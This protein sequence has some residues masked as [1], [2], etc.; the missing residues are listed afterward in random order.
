MTLSPEKLNF[1][2]SNYQKLRGQSAPMD[3]VAQSMGADVSSATDLIKGFEGFRGEAYMPTPNDVPTV[4]YGNTQGVQMGQ[5]ITEEE[6]SKQ[7]QDRVNNLSKQIDE[8]VK[9]PLTRNQ[10]T[11]LISLADNVGIGALGM[12]E[13][14]RRLNAGD[15]EGF[16]QGAFGEGGFIRQKGEILPGLVKR[17]TE[18]ARL[19]MTPDGP[20]TAQPKEMSIE[21]PQPF[22]RPK[23]WKDTADQIFRLPQS[24]GEVVTNLAV[25][26]PMYMAEVIAG[27][28]SLPFD[29]SA[30]TAKKIGQ[31]GQQIMAPLA[32]TTEWGNQAL[33][34]IGQGFEFVL[35]PAH[36]V[37]D[38]IETEGKRPALA[39]LTR[40]AGEFLTLGA[41]HQGVVNV[42][43]GVKIPA[44]LRRAMQREKLKINPDERALLN[45]L[46]P[47]AEKEAAEIISNKEHPITQE[48]RDRQAAEIARANAEAK[49]SYETLKGVMKDVKPQPKD[50]PPQAQSIMETA[51]AIKE[52]RDITTS[53][54]AVAQRRVQALSE[55][56][57][58]LA[59]RGLT[60]V[61]GKGVVKLEDVKPAE[62]KPVGAETVVEQPVVNPRT[63]PQR[64]ASVVPE[65]QQV[66]PEV[67]PEM[68]RS[69]N[70]GSNVIQLKP[71]Q[72]VTWQ[73]GKQT[74]E[75]EILSAG[76]KNRIKVITS[77]GKVKYPKREL[78]KIEDEAVKNI[79]PEAEVIK[80]PVEQPV[81]LDQKFKSDPRSLTV[82]ELKQLE[83]ESL[84]RYQDADYLKADSFEAYERSLNDVRKELRHR[85]WFEIPD[86]P[87]IDPYAPPKRKSFA[88][89]LK[90]KEAADPAFDY[91]DPGIFKDLK[92]AFGDERGALFPEKLTPEQARVKAEAIERLVKKLK[93]TG[94][95]MVDALIEAGLDPD[96]AREVA[97]KLGEKIDEMGK[98]PK[99]LLMDKEGDV[100]VK[101][102]SWKFK[103]Q[104][105]KKPPVFMSDREAMKRTPD[106]PDGPLKG[107]WTPAIR[108]FD[109]LDPVFKELYYKEREARLA[110]D[111]ELKSE[112]EFLH[113]LSK[114]LS[115]KE[116]EELGA[117]W[118]NLQENGGKIL[119]EMGVKVVKEL[120]AN[121]EKAFNVLTSKFE[122]LFNRI[123]NAR[124]SIGQRPMSKV[125][126]YLT[127]F[128]ENGLLE[129]FGL[130]TNL[131]NDKVFEI[132]NAHQST[133]NATG[134][135]FRHRRTGNTR[136]VLLNP[137]EVYSRYIQQGIPHIHVSPVVAKVHELLGDIKSP[138][139]GR[140][141]KFSDYKPNAARFLSGW[142][143]QI[144]GVQEYPLSPAIRK[145]T[146]ILKRNITDAML[147]GNV[148]TFLVQPFALIQA[149]TE[150]PVKS[151]IGGMMELTKQG[152]KRGRGESDVLVNRVIDSSLD[153]MY[154][155]IKFRKYGRVKDAINQQ[156]RKATFALDPL[157]AGI[158]WEMGRYHG[159]KVL[160]LTGEALKRYADDLVV[161][162]NGSGAKGDLAP[163]Q[164]QGIGSLATHLQTFV[165]S[166]WNFLAKDVFGYRG[167]V[168][169]TRERFGKIAK[170]ILGVTAANIFFE[171]ILGV[172]SPFP[173]PVRTAKESSEKGDNP[174]MTGVKTAGNLL[175]MMPGPVGG[176]RYS[177]SVFGPVG[178][179]AEES[180]RQ[181]R[182][183]GKLDPLSYGATAAGIGGVNQIRKSVRAA[184][185]G[186]DTL[187]IIL[188][189]YPEK[190][191]GS[192]RSRRRPSRSRRRR[193]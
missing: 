44:R 19:F 87:V 91:R 175:T 98:S 142:A 45:E 63:A 5:S 4:G 173:T 28:G 1:F 89:I 136:R 70:E 26:M 93:S 36:K 107:T 34:Q 60:Y 13:S 181:F 14:L 21:Y 123:N 79:T 81:N 156:G 143:N 15:Y 139:T 16:V 141:A 83:A 120:S 119:Q 2:K 57:K 9:V 169:P 124:I 18:E 137:I 171:D 37:A 6:A 190:T 75:G 176:L 46:I 110:S 10:K 61:P 127:F 49:Q 68:L 23:D 82:D 161:K 168:L 42:A 101:Q 38:W 12:S 180:A 94:K 188:G 122:E 54:E 66:Q 157:V 192:R 71:G 84:K 162:T 193:D 92:N 100:I 118:I 146:N 191:S 48:I 97:Q 129:D 185:G 51:E 167:K 112:K 90:A 164:N 52:S 121:Q 56:Q 80:Q 47:K 133:A 128:R 99:S 78:I 108:Q 106:L 165:I 178:E 113:T 189:R 35:Y 59:D 74:L 3:T 104:E 33:G 154:A 67:Q 184:K 95:R 126:N 183:E 116:W 39:Y 145:A 149:A 159:E 170:F 7:V 144:A 150:L 8:M 111:L 43:K 31:Y 135:R 72:K 86:D 147:I 32:P 148:R 30:E 41:L 11:A 166:Q 158:T 117:Y 17:R 115:R 76:G 160:G 27:V 29:P 138:R 22:Q 25:G 153:D 85:E 64:Q 73:D 114:E 174:V 102:R 186:E 40:V 151:M 140:K 62:V 172:P 105:L 65:V 130:R 20:Q 50:V 103:G 187:G 69:K 152:F 132:N 179:F 134:F 109:R 96:A 155:G 53:N 177:S 125:E 55:Y 58:F 77:N 182:G 163:I 131:V 24:F 88:E